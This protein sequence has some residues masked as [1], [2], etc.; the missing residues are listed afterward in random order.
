MWLVYLVKCS[1][2]LTVPEPLLEISMLYMF[3]HL[4]GRY[5]RTIYHIKFQLSFLMTLQLDSG[6][7]WCRGIDIFGDA[8]GGKMNIG[9]HQAGEI[10]IHS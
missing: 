6:C 8:D 9:L 4:F 2:Y 10:N 5:N 3:I 7:R 1:K